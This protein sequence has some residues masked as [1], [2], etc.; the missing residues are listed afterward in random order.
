MSQAAQT[1]ANG[2]VRVLVADDSRVIRRAVAKILG[3]DFEIVEAEDGEDGWDKLVPDERIQ[4]LITDIMMPRLDGYGFICRVRASDVSRIRSIPIIVITGAQDEVTK[5]R[6]YACGATDFITKPMD[7][8]QLIARTRAHAR[9]DETTRKLSETECALGEQSA[10]DP[11]TNLRSRRYLIER[12]TQDIAYAKRHDVELAAIRLDIDQFRDLLAA[13]GEATANRALRWV[14]NILVESTRTEDSVA[15]L[16]DSEFAILA[17]ASS[18][19]D[20]AVVCE[21]I[22]ASVAARPFVDGNVSLPLTASLGLTTLGRDGADTIEALLNS[23]GQNLALARAGGGNRLGVGYEEEI[24]APE[25]SILEQPDLETA[26]KM[27]EKGEGG[28]LIPYL[29]ELTLRI[30]PLLT[31]ASQNLDLDLDLD[32]ESLKEKLAPR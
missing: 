30:A 15:R 9:L 16:V 4:V 11:V 12:G 2:K 18:R 32:I 3:S 26:L 13:H 23:A 27:L 21:R 20:A 1:A 24:A 10:V 6:A 22:R 14:A 8:M 28:K 5:E 19:I 29:P 25:E 17:P 31:F 7:S